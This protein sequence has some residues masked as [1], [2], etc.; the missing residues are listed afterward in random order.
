LYN[1]LLPKRAGTE[2]AARHHAMVPVRAV[3]ATKDGHDIHADEYYATWCVK[4][5][6]AWHDSV[7]G[8]VLS[9][10][11]KR[12]MPCG[13][14]PTVT[15]YRRLHLTQPVATDHDFPYMN[16]VPS[17]LMRVP[18]SESRLGP[19]NIFL[20]EEGVVSLNHHLQELLTAIRRSP[21]LRTPQMLV[22]SDGGVDYRPRPDESVFLQAY[23]LL[24]LQLDFL[25]FATCEPGGSK[26]V[27]ASSNAKSGLRRGELICA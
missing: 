17:G 20:C 16:I 6:W 15:R 27:R 7:G 14:Q 3:R 2:E 1:Y 23:T 19:V 18:S 11:S 25:I 12:K 24:V 26:K 10:D 21:E 13:C 9:R 5:L 22:L 4:A 8:T